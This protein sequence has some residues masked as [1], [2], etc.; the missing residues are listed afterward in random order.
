MT[1][2]TVLVGKMCTNLT[3]TGFLTFPDQQLHMYCL[4]KPSR[5]TF[6]LTITIATKCSGHSQMLIFAIIPNPSQN[7]HTYLVYHGLEVMSSLRQMQ[8]SVYTDNKE[9]EVSRRQKEKAGKHE[10]L[11]VNI[12]AA[13]AYMNSNNVSSPLSFTVLSPV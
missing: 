12:T 9:Y 10:R 2:C 4:L 11:N 8:Y 5:Q 1:R 3:K 7:T 6:A 13:A